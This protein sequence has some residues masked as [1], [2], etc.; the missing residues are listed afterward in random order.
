MTKTKAIALLVAVAGTAF[1]FYNVFSRTD[2]WETRNNSGLEAYQKGLYSEAEKEFVAAL[3]AAEKFSADG[4]R[5][6]M[7]LDQ[8]VQIYQ[9]QSKYIEAEPLI[10]RVLAIDEKKLGPEHPNVAASLNNLAGNYRLRGKYQ[11]A[12][13]FIKRALAILEKAWGPEDPDVG[14]V[15]AHYANILRAMGRNAEA[16]KLEAGLKI[17]AEKQ[18]AKN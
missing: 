10:R 1:Y 7:S 8:L 15:R 17:T 2:N 9:I 16:E 3:K 4:S 12:E 11:E 18:T 6:H 13:P 14:M 5:L